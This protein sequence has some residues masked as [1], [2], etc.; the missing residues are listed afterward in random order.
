MKEEI[1]KTDVMVLAAGSNI[2]EAMFGRLI[3]LHVVNPH[4][5]EGTPISTIYTFQSN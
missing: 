1:A 2:P 3:L 4:F 5:S